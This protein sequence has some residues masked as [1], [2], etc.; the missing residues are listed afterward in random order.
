MQA[1]TDAALEA[2]MKAIILVLAAAL[3][4][5]SGFTGTAAAAT[6]YK[7]KDAHGAMSYQQ[8]PCANA[9]Q[10]AGVR[11]YRAERDNP[12][13][14]WSN[15]V[16]QGSPARYAASSDDSSWSAPSSNV[17]QS[18]S[19][20]QAN[21]RAMAAQLDSQISAIGTPN[22]RSKRELLADLL[23]QKVALVTDSPAR[24]NARPTQ[25]E[26]TIERTSVVTQPIHV[27]DQYGNGYTQPPGSAFATD[28]KTGKQCFVY[29]AFVDCK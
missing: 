25:R 26:T 3:I 29:G 20:D 2:R 14:N 17:S 27:R 21:R 5:T 10:E 28:D 12:G 4:Q 1:R 7:C 19:A 18:S 8:M 6:L 11:N 15:Q 16:A 23:A 22:S 13:T 9:K 24:T